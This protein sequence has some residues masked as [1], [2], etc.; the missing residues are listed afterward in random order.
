M[1]VI[2]VERGVEI[3]RAE[4][5]RVDDLAWVQPLSGAGDTS[6][7]IEVGDAVDHHFRVD[8][9]VAH[10][11]FE[12]ERADGIRHAAD[13]DLQAVAVLDFRRDE[14]SDGAIDLVGGGFGSSGDG[15]S[16]PSIT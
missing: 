14:P 2:A 13:P 9:K 6:C 16:S 12:Q 3:A 5:E 7:L 8:A 1:S 15:A 4:R 11:A 10:A